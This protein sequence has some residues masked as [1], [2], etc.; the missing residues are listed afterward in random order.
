[1]KIK[2]TLLLAAAAFISI[3]ANAQKNQIKQVSSPNGNI[4]ITVEAASKLLWSVT[5]K[6]QQVI[7]PSAIA[8]HLQ[9]GEVLGVLW[10]LDQLFGSHAFGNLYFALLPHTRDICLPRLAHAADEA[11]RTA[12]Q[13]NVRA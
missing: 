9:G 7:M 13:K 6:G 3:A 2:F 4:I 5:H 1:M 10:D 12:E 11:I 8:I